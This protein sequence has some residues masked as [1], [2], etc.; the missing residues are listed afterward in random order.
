MVKRPTPNAQV[1]LFSYSNAGDGDGRVDAV[2]IQKFL[3]TFGA[4]FSL[5]EVE[6][7]INEES[8]HP[9][10][11]LDFPEFVCMLSRLLGFALKKPVEVSRATLHRIFERWDQDGDGYLSAND[12]RSAVKEV[13]EEWSDAQVNDMIYF[14]NTNGLFTFQ[15]LEDII[16][17]KVQTI[18]DD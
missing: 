5:E 12:L 17:E 10:G 16:V 4:H 11:V 6:E 1:H 18:D 7:F 9:N 3:G 8:A 14:K 2:D 15:D 13:G